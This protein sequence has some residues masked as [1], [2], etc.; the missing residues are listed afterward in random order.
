MTFTVL[1]DAD[2]QTLLSKL[3]QKDVDDLTF[4]L[5]EALTQ[6]SCNNELP[7]QP[8]RA[9]V[10]RPNGQVSLFMPATTPSSIGVK[11]VGV[12]PSQTPPPGEKPKPGLRSVLTICDELG[13]AVGVL[14][15]AELT[16]FRTSLGSMLVYR[17]RK[18]TENVVVF[19]A[20][21]Q[22]EWHIR[23]AVLLKGKDIRRITIVNRSSARAKDLVKSLATAG[24]GSH[25]Q[26]RVFEGKEDEFE[27]LVKEADVI[28]C[29]T[30][31]TTPLFPAS[32]LAS[33]A[34]KPRYISAIGSYR[35]DMQEIDPELLTQITT[36]SGP[37][38]PQVYDACIIVDSIKG[39]MD[40]AGELVKAGIATEKMLEVGR[41]D[42]F[43]EE[44]DVRGGDKSFGRPGEEAQKH[45]S[46]DSLMSIVDISQ[47]KIKSHI[48][49]SPQLQFHLLAL[50]VRTMKFALAFLSISLLPIL[51]IASP[52]LAPTS[53][54]ATEATITPPPSRRDGDYAPSIPLLSL[55]I[56]QVTIAKPSIK[57]FSLDLPPPT[58][59]PGF[60]AYATPGVDGYVP[61]EACNALWAYF[62]N[63]AAAV[64]FSALFGILTIAHLCQAVMYRNGFCWV[65]IMAGLWETGAYAFRT[66]GS[67]D[68]QSSGIATVAQILVLVAPIWVNAFAYMVFA[69][70]VHFYSPTRKV[71]FFSPSIL[72]LVFVTLDIVSFVVQLVGGGMAGPGSSAESQK[73]GLDLY[74]GGIGMQEAFIVLFLGLVIRFHRDQLQ[75]ER[76]E[77]LTAEKMRWRW[78]IWT[79]YECLLAITIRIIYRLVE[80]SAGLGAT[81]P[82]P[83]NEPLL[84]QNAAILAISSSPLLFW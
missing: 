21:K 33:E 43:K 38:A 44:E 18:A 67:K 53:R 55:D 5:N 64:A 83:S 35:L 48:R 10:T 77:C 7:Y 46:G 42:E 2:I 57:S 61:G 14:N 60:S 11:I 36:P 51:S 3:T 69:R 72:A 65:I 75:A 15:A 47:R 8:H 59:T 12:A 40:E 13:Q 70:I 45:N 29:T 31:S 76:V 37:F 58:C 30:P 19:G 27:S 50:P 68:Q 63:F 41:I 78:L 82:L 79:L 74:M 1:A 39:C 49:S 66:L 73:K 56:P 17:H 6:Y 25:I 26:I 22:A 4:S 52:S 9:N 84:C 80:F 34:S 16:A 28:F 24:V 54:I 32:H 62:P 81:N 20:G 71:W 23:L